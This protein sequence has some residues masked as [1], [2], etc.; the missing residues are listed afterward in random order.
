MEKK[1]FEENPK[2]FVHRGVPHDDP[3]LLKEVINQFF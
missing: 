1:L 2:L 3:N